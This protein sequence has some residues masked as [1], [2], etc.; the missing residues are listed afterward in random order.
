MRTIVVQNLKIIPFAGHKTEIWDFELIG[1][2]NFM[3]TGSTDNE[4]RLWQISHNAGDHDEEDIPTVSVVAFMAHNTHPSLILC[5][6]FSVWS[7]STVIQ[8]TLKT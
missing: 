6:T 1:G 5:C 7:L 8:N 3:V 4:I 2:E